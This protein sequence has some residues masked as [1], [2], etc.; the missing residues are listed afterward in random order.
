MGLIK[1]E[2]QD[3]DSHLVSVFQPSFKEKRKQ[4]A[5]FRDASVRITGRRLWD[6]CKPHLNAH[7]W[8]AWIIFAI[9]KAKAEL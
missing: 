2:R 7:S 8:S 5:S 3:G 9:L 4:E 1:Q 6:L